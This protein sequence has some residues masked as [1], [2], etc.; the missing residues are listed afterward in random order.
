VVDGVPGAQAAA[1][2]TADLGPGAAA[3]SAGPLP[4]GATWWR[5]ALLALLLAPGEPVLGDLVLAGKLTVWDVKSCLAQVG[6]A[7]VVEGFWGRCWRVACASGLRAHAD[8]YDRRRVAGSA[9]L[10]RAPDVWREA[11]HQA[12]LGLMGEPETN[13]CAER[14]IR[15]LKELVTEPVAS[16]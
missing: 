4:V 8:V 3:D 15:T 12:C 5:L 14:W 7:L 10:V 6:V 11:G 13:G 2:V 16:W 1:L 9:D